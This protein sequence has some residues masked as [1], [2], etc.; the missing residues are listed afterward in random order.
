MDA[1]LWLY[2]LGQDYASGVKDVTVLPEHIK[3]VSDEH[4]QQVIEAWHRANAEARFLTTATQL[5]C[6]A[7][8]AEW[9]RRYG[10]HYQ[11]SAT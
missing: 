6:I 9:K 4:L 5:Y 1:K 10:S 3:T 11:P 2:N 7:A 8:N